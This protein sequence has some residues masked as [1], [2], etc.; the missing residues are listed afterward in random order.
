MEAP[1]TP[2][3]ETQST[4][5][6]QEQDGDNASESEYVA[7]KAV[8]LE[9]IGQTIGS[10]QFIYPS[11]KKNLSYIPIT[12]GTTVYGMT[13]ASDCLSGYAR[14][15]DSFE[16]ST[17]NYSR[18][19]LYLMAAICETV[20]HIEVPDE[21]K[22]E[23]STVRHMVV[24][25]ALYSKDPKGYPS[26]KDDPQDQASDEVDVA[27]E[28]DF[29]G[30]RV[31][32][33]IYHPRIDTAKA[34]ANILNI[35]RREI[36]RR[37]SQHSSQYNSKVHGRDAGGETTEDWKGHKYIRNL[38]HLR[39]LYGAVYNGIPGTERDTASELHPNHVLNPGNAMG[40]SY[41]RSQPI[42]N[43]CSSQ[44]DL[45]SYLVYDGRVSQ[46][47][48]SGESNPPTLPLKGIKFPCPSRTYYVKPTDFNPSVLRRMAFPWCPPV[49]VV[50]SMLASYIRSRG[51]NPRVLDRIPVQD[52]CYQDNEVIR[53]VLKALSRVTHR[54]KKEEE[55]RARVISRS[56]GVD[57]RA[58]PSGQSLGRSRHTASR[59]VNMDAIRNVFSSAGM[60]EDEEEDEEE[61]DV[62]GISSG[63]AGQ[64]GSSGDQEEGEGADASVTLSMLTRQEMDA[65][66]SMNNSSGD[67]C[68]VQFVAGGNSDVQFEE[69][70]DIDV[71]ELKDILE[72]DDAMR[73]LMN[74]S[75]FVDIFG[76][77]SLPSEI[78]L[79]GIKDASDPRVMLDPL[80]PCRDIL[81][82]E[83]SSLKER[84]TRE[85]Y[86][87][88]DIFAACS[89]WLVDAM[90]TLES[91]VFNPNAIVSPATAATSKFYKQEVHTRGTLVDT[92]K[93]SFRLSPFADMIMQTYVLA[94][95]S[96]LY[97]LTGHFDW[98]LVSIA[99]G[100]TD[101]RRDV[102]PDI[103][104]VGVAEAGKS[105]HLD[106]LEATRIAGT[107]EKEEYGSKLSN[108]GKVNNDQKVILRHEEQMSK[109]SSRVSGDSMS[110]QISLSKSAATQKVL[111]TNHITINKEGQRE[112][113][114]TFSLLNSVAISCANEFQADP[115]M[116]TRRFVYWIPY[117]VRKGYSRSEM[118]G[119]PDRTS[120]EFNEYADT[121]R[122]LDC[123][124]RIVYALKW[125][126]LLPQV[127]TVAGDLFLRDFVESAKR[128]GCNTG[129]ARD[130]HRIMCI[131]TQ[132]CIVDAYSYVF[133]NE[134]TRLNL[135]TPMKLQQF[136]HLAPHLYIT[137]EHMATAITLMHQVF[138]NPLQE[139]VL[140]RIIQEFI[141]PNVTFRKISYQEALQ[142][143]RRYIRFRNWYSA[144]V[145]A[146]KNRSK[147]RNAQNP[148]SLTNGSGASGEATVHAQTSIESTSLQGYDDDDLESLAE[149]LERD[150]RSP[151]VH[152]EGTSQSVREKEDGNESDSMTYDSREAERLMRD[153]VSTPSGIHRVQSTGAA[154]EESKAQEDTV[155]EEEEVRALA[156]EIYNSGI[157]IDFTAQDD[158]TIPPA[159]YGIH[160]SF[161]VFVGRIRHSTGKE[162]LDYHIVQNVLSSL[163]SSS[164]RV[165]KVMAFEEEARRMEANGIHLTREGYIVPGAQDEIPPE[166]AAS[167]ESIRNATLSTGSMDR[168]RMQDI[169]GFTEQPGGA[170]E[171]GTMGSTSTVT[172]QRLL[173]R[174][175]TVF[176]T[177]QVARLQEYEATMPP[178]SAGGRPAPKQ[179]HGTY[180]LLD[181]FTVR[182]ALL[183]VYKAKNQMYDVSELDILTKCMKDT[184]HN[185]CEERDI[186]LPISAGDEEKPYIPHV[187]HLA[188]NPRKV[189]LYRDPKRMAT[190]IRK[191]FT[192]DNQTSS[193]DVGKKIKEITNTPAS[194]F[195][196]QVCNGDVEVNMDY[197]ELGWIA[198]M[199]N[200]EIPKSKRIFYMSRT[201][202]KKKYYQKRVEARQKREMRQQREIYQTLVGKCRSEKAVLDAIEKTFRDAVPASRTVQLTKRMYKIQ[203]DHLRDLVMKTINSVYCPPMTSITEDTK[204]PPKEDEQDPFIVDLAN[205]F[206]VS[207]GQSNKASKLYGMDEEDG[208]VSA[209]DIDRLVD[210][211]IEHQ[212]TSGGNSI[213]DEEK[214]DEKMG[215]DLLRRDAK[216]FSDTKFLTH[217]LRTGA[218]SSGSSFFPSQPNEQDVLLSCI[219]SVRS[220]V[221][222][223]QE[224]TSS[225]V[226]SIM[227]NED[228]RIRAQ[229]SEGVGSS[230]LRTDER[231]GAGT[232]G[233]SS[234]GAS[235]GRP[236]ERKRPRGQEGS[237]DAGGSD[238]D[239]A[240]FDEIMSKKH[241][242][243][244]GEDDVLEEFEKDTPEE[245]TEAQ[246]RQ[247]ELAR[248]MMD[249]AEEALSVGG[250]QQQA[251][252]EDA[253][254]TPGGDASQKRMR[255]LKAVEERTQKGYEEGE[256]M[257]EEEEETM[258]T[259][260]VL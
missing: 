157:D 33:I 148:S 25:E 146:R 168:D 190:D 2:R 259:E 156:D 256:F 144:E 205:Q 70:G 22:E 128:N 176:D 114:K 81:D 14:N 197:D 49:I 194:K 77:R 143:A 90:G 249:I 211:E 71:E 7:N 149:R 160:T 30:F 142:R 133:R 26:S 92:F 122:R 151:G 131:A 121:I 87:E 137:V 161:D 94:A 45:F 235:R 242:G 209:E 207:T 17:S 113:V 10:S 124:S 21:T 206:K 255:L 218:S 112:S 245:L 51:G 3:S 6:V 89:K 174:M 34:T 76:A 65:E 145:R 91:M 5:S 19:L 195:F 241:R 55:A 47:G 8:R 13:I 229:R 147:T 224:V 216:D 227:S 254:Q 215:K 125:V 27:G 212:E 258:E 96:R 98:L 54:Q 226:F 126:N 200:C 111:E 97:S 173:N 238:E 204:N 155:R 180:F 48:P 162:N 60:D 159:Q 187:V 115:A 127:T 20:E 230:S 196:Q 73:D 223:G 66:R 243:A 69:T 44:K 166:L 257:E 231:E 100:C 130:M 251:P 252:A 106:D 103:T 37:E 102:T 139:E 140:D 82:Y 80:K 1:E 217:M 248:S 104:M 129:N 171:H 38:S 79:G 101:Y 61:D 154:S 93:G 35:N 181:R 188:P 31:F 36:S 99:A 85:G 247:A 167:Q 15:V 246:R 9:R 18:S 186:M 57:G 110:D 116:L 43:V 68:G 182:K 117:R 222:S 163:R 232:G 260:H 172:P 214:E 50:R 135:P 165:D 153:G 202:F 239:D 40:M 191:Y 105:K 250:N 177:S 233:R 84:L 134:D 201:K 220:M 118:K 52:S 39:N 64:P 203:S 95:E 16:G 152:E 63:G 185:K 237:E 136:L 119:K 164:T 240:D 53:L 228:V 23:T 175:K 253:Q 24:M 208:E 86:S 178:P 179:R 109:V 123:A 108:T 132:L 29:R 120:P 192:I 169:R 12:H 189:S 158:G 11:C 42:R 198:H 74:A 193:S 46:S 83:K 244:G 62:V 56:L 184:C 75:H 107:F 58:G 234:R 150:G 138:T 199:R 28:N 170:D 221:E 78:A 210:Q 32:H 88:E 183:R 67:L 41:M 72:Q 59:T 219:K 225:N 141:Y 236:E 213:L 4:H